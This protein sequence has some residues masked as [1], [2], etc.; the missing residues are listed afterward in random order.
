MTGYLFPA[1]GRVSMMHRVSVN[2]D[3]LRRSLVMT[4]RLS[5]DTYCFL[6]A[7]WQW[8]CVVCERLLISC[9]QRLKS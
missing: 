2:T 7:K 8:H 3:R 5:V 4:E 6:G 1:A 9:H